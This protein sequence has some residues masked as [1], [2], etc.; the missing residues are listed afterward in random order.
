MSAAKDRR[1]IA[2]RRFD[3]YTS[4]KNDVIRKARTSI[5][6]EDDD[7][8]HTTRAERMHRA[9][10]DGIK[11]PIP[12]DPEPDYSSKRAY[13]NMLQ[14][15]IEKK[16]SVSFAKKHG[17]KETQALDDIVNDYSR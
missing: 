6:H 5:L 13:L 15:S 1:S 17:T 8:I 12:D 11:I 7:E 3:P 16:A 2:Y 9:M 10:R 14:N 4:N